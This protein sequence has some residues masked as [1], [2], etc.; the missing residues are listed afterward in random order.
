MIKT[1]QPPQN[2]GQLNWVAKRD[3]H[4][5]MR[6][7][8]RWQL[9]NPVDTHLKASYLMLINKK[10]I[11][12]SHWVSIN[13]RKVLLDKVRGPQI[14]HSLSLA[15]Y[16]SVIAVD[17]NGRI[18]LVRQYRPALENYTIELPGGLLDPHETPEFCAK[19]E[20][21]EEI[22]LSP[23]D[24]MKPLPCLIPD[25]GR[26]ENRLWGFFA[27]VEGPVVTGW[28]AEIGVEPI[29]VTRNE[30]LEMILNGEFNHALHVALIGLAS[31]KGFLKF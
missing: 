25:T 15:D 9:Q 23:K 28:R 27:Q 26:L 16:V 14:F 2:P 4:Q 19:R 29:F 8:W 1:N 18:P 20:L 12:L 21:V 5:M 11:K 7:A 30:L 6:Y 10:K 22:G 17:E 31:A 24:Q 13:E 3:L